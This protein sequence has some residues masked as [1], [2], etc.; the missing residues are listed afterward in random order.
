MSTSQSN[1]VFSATYKCEGVDLALRL[2]ELPLQLR[3][4][5]GT[6]HSYSDSRLNALIIIEVGSVSGYG[7]CGLPPKKPGVY[8]ADFNDIKIYIEAL[9]KKIRELVAVAEST[10]YNPF[11]GFEN[12]Y[13]TSMH[14]KNEESVQIKAL[15]AVFRALDECSLNVEKFSCPAR[16]AV[17]IALFDAWGKLANKPIYELIGIEPAKK[18]GFYTA[19]LN[20]EIDLIVEATTFGLQYTPNIKI[21][22][23]RDMALGSQVVTRLSQLFK[24]KVD[25]HVS[26]YVWSIDANSDWTPAV[27]MEFLNNVVLNKE[28]PF[29]RC[30]MLEQP[31]SAHLTPEEFEEWKVVRQEYSKHGIL[32]F[33][34]ES[35]HNAKQVEELQDIIDGAN[36]KMDKAGG[37]RE[38]LRTILKAQELNKKVW[39]GMMVASSLS[40]VAHLHLLPLSTVG[41]DLD[42]SLLVKDT[43]DPVTA[44]SWGKFG[45]QDYGLIAPWNKPGIGVDKK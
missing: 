29:T 22:L 42:G 24:E 8:Y 11:T 14:F 44:I 34:D 38:A 40:T 4:T 6:S 16:N 39:I 9:D 45:S 36:V 3:S 27:A 31:F 30:Y 35:I 2:V 21:K 37:Y 5:F 10:S 18:K 41:G 13:F 19:A 12:K 17:E 28:H 20:K 33:A 43:S 15:R 26:D 23:N 25:P 32:I 7:E 1:T